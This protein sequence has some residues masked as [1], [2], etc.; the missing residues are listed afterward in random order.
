MKLLYKLFRADPDSRE[1]VVAAT[2]GLG[3]L[4]NVMIA[5]IK[6]IVGLL[7]SS[8]AIISDFCFIQKQGY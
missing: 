1:G 8:I 3:I 5:A 7:T 2:S 6:V 4:A